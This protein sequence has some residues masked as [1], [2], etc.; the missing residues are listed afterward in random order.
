MA[1]VQISRDRITTTAK[2]KTQNVLREKRKNK[3]GLGLLFTTRSLCHLIQN[4]FGLMWETRRCHGC[5]E[6]W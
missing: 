1:K 2:R 3:N 6:G 5:L 4:T